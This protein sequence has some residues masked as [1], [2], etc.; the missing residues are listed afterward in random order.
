MVSDHVEPRPGDPGLDI[1]AVTGLRRGAVI[2]GKYRIDALVGIG[3]MGAVLAAHHVELDERVAIKVLSPQLLTNQEALSRFGLE[4]RAAVKMKSECA[5][6]TFDVGT[7]ENG[8]PYIVMELLEGVDLGQWLLRDGP[9]PTELAVDFVMQA[10]V[11]LAEAH[12]LGI[13]HRDVK[14][15]NLFCTRRGEGWMFIKVLDFGIS[16]ATC[17]APPPGGSI[18]A[19]DALVGSPLHMSP[20][21]MRGTS[22]I[23]GRTDIWGL[24]ATLYE[25]LAG[26]P[27]F[28]GDTFVDIAIQV[29]MRRPPPLR[30]WRPDVPELLEQVILKCLEK[31]VAARYPTV[32]ALTSALAPFGSPHAAFWADKCA[33]FLGAQ[34]RT[35]S[36]SPAARMASIA[37][38][39]VT[40]TGI[41]LKRIHL[42]LSAAVVALGAVTLPR[43]RPRAP[44][45]AQLDTV[46]ASASALPITPEAVSTPLP[47]HMPPT[48]DVEQL[49]PAPRPPAPRRSP[50]A[51]ESLA[52]SPDAGTTAKVIPLSVSRTDPCDPP[53]TIDSAGHRQYKPECP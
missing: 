28:W 21:Q 52:P 25:L 27:A 24:G 38:V 4:A 50:R 1:E 11:A 22:A 44:S 30:H 35:R 42:G 31:D 20:E 5:A 53:Y 13:V 45:G 36:S 37:P 34:T 17:A 26:V 41:R 40:K 10:C 7:L 47:A 39:S 2:A 12:S 46:V 32:V 49:P 33:A 51:R 3:G 6:R 16:K 9:L 43:L 48:I 23:D 18:T 15:S 29:T 8:T 14:P 19:P